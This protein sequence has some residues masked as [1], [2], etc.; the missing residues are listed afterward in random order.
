MLPTQERIKEL[1]TRFDVTNGQFFG[2]YRFK[3][4][5]WYLGDG[6]MTPAEK[7]EWFNYGDIRE[8]DIPR[9]QALL[10]PGE[11]LT[12]GWKELGPDKKDDPVFRNGF[13]VWL[14][15]TCDGVQ[16]DVR[17]NRKNLK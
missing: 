15:I 14:V 3:N 11:I 1:Q 12:L 2:E 13:G 17:E 4:L 16:F 6:I 5:N 9:V 7:D 10:V 8:E